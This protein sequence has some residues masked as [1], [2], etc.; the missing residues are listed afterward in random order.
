MHYGDM[1]RAALP[2]H[3]AAHWTDERLRKLG[4]ALARC[5]AHYGWKFGGA[6][7]HPLALL[8]A[9]AWPLAWPIAAPYVMPYVQKAL[10]RK[11]AA[12]PAGQGAA[13]ASPAPPP[14]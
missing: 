11:G 5:A 4:E 7:T 12:A 13:Q 3:A 9:A 10:E 2:E 1:V 14:A 6:L 8:A